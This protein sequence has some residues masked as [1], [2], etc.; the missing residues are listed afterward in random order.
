M[1]LGC[2]N[3]N[4][5]HCKVIQIEKD[6]LNDYSSNETWAPIISYLTIPTDLK[7][8]CKLLSHLPAYKNNKRDDHI[9]GA[10]HYDANSL[11]ILMNDANANSSIDTPMMAMEKKQ[12]WRVATFNC[13]C[14]YDTTL[15]KKFKICTF[16]T[17]C[18][19][20]VFWH[21]KPSITSYPVCTRSDSWDTISL[22]C[23]A[24][25]C[26]AIIFW[27]P[28]H[29]RF[30]RE[31]ETWLSYDDSDISNEI[32]QTPKEAQTLNTTHSDDK[33][34]KQCSQ[35]FESAYQ[36]M[37][38]KATTDQTR[39]VFGNLSILQ[40]SIQRNWPRHKTDADNQIDSLTNTSIE[41][42]HMSPKKK[43]NGSRKLLQELPN[44]M[45]SMSCWT[46][47]PLSQIDVNCPSTCTSEFNGKFNIHAS[48][49]RER[50]RMIKQKICSIK[51][52]TSMQGYNDW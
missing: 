22:P 6:V 18:S 51:Q 26:A 43:L 37:K 30:Y 17:V 31:M 29:S 23:L 2:I 21:D 12:E 39:I 45:D 50:T 14:D 49:K 20:L 1:C 3:E 34:L 19:C 36:E 10:T 5:R 8:I 44:R 42:E 35:S 41:Q 40:Q 9:Y 7:R 28:F 11:G 25:R 24:Y 47:T 13:R 32:A 52:K 46:R 48:S 16:C 33:L 27:N 38:H 15:Q 4:L